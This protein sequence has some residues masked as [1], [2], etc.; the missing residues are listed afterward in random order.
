M[1]IKL[2]LTV[3]EIS[4]KISEFYGPT[5]YEHKFNKAKFK[6]WLSIEFNLGLSSLVT[7][8]HNHYTT[9]NR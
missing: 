6:N 2:G 7:R 9:F 8:S 1:L 3:S 4:T 5:N